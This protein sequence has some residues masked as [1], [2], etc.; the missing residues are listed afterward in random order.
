MLNT[1]EEREQ[2]HT[3]TALYN[4]TCFINNISN[5]ESFQSENRFDQIV[6]KRCE[7]RAD[8]SIQQCLCVFTFTR[9]TSLYFTF[10]LLS[11][12]Y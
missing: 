5:S 1:K 6:G 11:V 9:N 10:T 3:V 8:S 7:I 4:N 12:L 2:K